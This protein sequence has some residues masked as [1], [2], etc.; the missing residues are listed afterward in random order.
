MVSPQRIDLF[1]CVMS[2]Q[3]VSYP[4]VFLGQASLLIILG[5][6]TGSKGIHIAREF[7]TWALSST[8]G[9][10]SIYYIGFPSTI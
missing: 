3:P 5:M 2:A 7:G 4:L 1:N 6:L 8:I 10:P 9:G